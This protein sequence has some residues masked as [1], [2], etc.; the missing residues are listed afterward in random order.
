MR[1]ELFHL[2][3]LLAEPDLVKTDERRLARKVAEQQRLAHPRPR[4]AS[5][6]A[7]R[8]KPRSANTLERGG[9]DLGPPSSS[10]AA[11]APMQSQCLGV[12][13]ARG[14]CHFEYVLTNWVRNIPCLGTCIATTA[15]RVSSTPKSPRRRG[16][17][18]FA[19]GPD[20]LVILVLQTGTGPS[21]KQ[22][23]LPGMETVAPT[24]H[25]RVKVT[26]VVRSIARGYFLAD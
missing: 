2:A 26:A 20:A 24:R 22:S 8:G 25:T 6:C 10:A 15:C 14:S 5:A 18:R 13:S 7:R 3:Q 23:S 9:E 16:P 19:L 1:A 12:H 17:H 21:S 4:R 11:N